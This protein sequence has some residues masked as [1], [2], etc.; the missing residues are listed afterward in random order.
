MREEKTLTYEIMLMFEDML[1]KLNELLECN[2]DILSIQ[3]STICN[4][5][6]KM[7]ILEMVEEKMQKHHS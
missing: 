4:M 7:F 6:S 3:H 2:V 1:W 5:S